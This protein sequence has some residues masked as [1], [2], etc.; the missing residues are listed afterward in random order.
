MIPRC[1]DDDFI[2]MFKNLGSMTLVAKE[3]GITLRSAQTRRVN[4]EKRYGIEL[5]VA[6]TQTRIKEMDF[7]EHHM[8]DGII[9]TCSDL[10]CWPGELTTA[11]K[12]FLATV[13]NMKPA[14]VCLNGDIFDGAKASRWGSAEWNTL[15]SVNDELRACREYLAKIKA[16][17]PKKARFIFV[18]G[19]HDNRFIRKLCEGSPE[20]SG[21]FGFDLRDHFP[22]WEF[23]YR[24]TVNPGKD[25]MTDFV[26]NWANGTHAAYNN[27]LRSG[28]NYVTGHTHRLLDRPF[29]DR[30]GRRYGIETGTLTDIDGPQSYYVAGRPVDWGSGF[31]VLTF[32]QGRLLRPEYVDV[33]GKNTISFRSQIVKV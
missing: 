1:S 31:P 20:F 16:V 15:P 22:G 4:I 3:L 17:A 25:S 10:H 6:E 19:N 24:F 28:C 12:A 11:Q 2:R 7:L 21:V 30:T 8:N 29:M 32:K 9:A 26:H 33:I 5:R 27:V 18:M 23:C 13:K 14:I